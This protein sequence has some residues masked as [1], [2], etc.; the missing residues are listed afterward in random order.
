MKK[1]QPTGEMY[2]VIQ[3]CTMDDI[4][5]VLSDSKGFCE[6]VAGSLPAYGPRVRAAWRAMGTDPT[7]PVNTAVVRFRADGTPRGIRIMHEY[8]PEEIE[9]KPKRRVKKSKLESSTQAKESG[10]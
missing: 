5:V 3:R 9:A 6:G 2:L 4:P 7:T 8:T 1:K 10:K